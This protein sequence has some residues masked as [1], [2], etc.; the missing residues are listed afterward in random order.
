MF[1]WTWMWE[2]IVHIVDIGGIVDHQGLNFL[3]KIIWEIS[4][5]KKLTKK[6]KVF[7]QYLPTASNIKIKITTDASTAEF[8][9]AKII[10]I[11]LKVLVYYSGET[12]ACD[13]SSGE[14]CV[15]KLLFKVKVNMG[16]LCAEATNRWLVE[17]FD[18]WC[19]TPH[20]AIFQLYHGDQ[21]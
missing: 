4:F 14:Q 3:W 5:D 10:K 18:F 11:M 13:C 7:L 12:R 16:W 15:L 19:L 8:A 2:V 9:G 6:K 17:W 20:S 1:L 21:F